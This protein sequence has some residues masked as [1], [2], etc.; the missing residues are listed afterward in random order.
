MKLLI[1]IPAYNEEDCIE[2]IIERTLAA[3]A[4]IIAQSPVTDVEIAAVSDGSTDRTAELL[5]RYAR[6]I[7]VVVFKENRATAQRSRLRGNNRMPSCWAF[8]ML[9]VPVSRASFQNSAGPYS[10]TTWTSSWA[11]D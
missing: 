10:R 11:A 9:T 6:Q 7:K 1:A 2:S 3:R 5:S 4:E 8:W